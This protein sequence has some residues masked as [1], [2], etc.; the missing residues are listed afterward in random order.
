MT[1]TFKQ[2]KA[3]QAPLVLNIEI[4]VADVMADID[5]VERTLDA[6]GPFTYNIPVAKLPYGAIV[7]GGMVIVEEAFNVGADANETLT[8]DVGDNVDDDEYTASA[9]SLEAAA[10]TA[11][12][13]TGYQYV[14]SDN[15]LRLQFVAGSAVTAA[16]T[17]TGKLRVIVEYIV[18]GRQHEVL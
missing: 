11:L 10:V 1:T 18:E 9:V 16:E 2:V 4:G 15:E 6:N 7:T 14:G 17:T 13:I 12:T 3:A 5:G 8:V